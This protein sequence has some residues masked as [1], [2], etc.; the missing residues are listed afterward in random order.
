MKK[1]KEKKFFPILRDY[2][3]SL[4]RKWY[5]EYKFLNNEGKLC[6]SK[7]SGDINHYNTV[8]QREEEAQK[9]IDYINK[10]ADTPPKRPG[11]RKALPVGLQDESLLIKL[12]EDFL[13]QRKS[14]VRSKS[15]STY[16]SVVYNFIHWLNENKYSSS[17]IKYFGEDLASKYIDSLSPLA[18]NT[19]NKHLVVLRM[20]FKYALKSKVIKSNPFESVDGFSKVAVPAAAFTPEQRYRLRREIEGEDP[21]LWLFCM[22]IFY[23]F[24]RPGELRMLKVENVWL[25]E[26]KIEIPA[27]VSKNKKR[28]FVQIPTQLAVMLEDMDI[29]QYPGNYYLFTADGYPGLKHVSINYMSN[30]FR[31]YLVK[32]KFSK[33]HVL[34]S[35]KH[36]GAAACA[37]AGIPV[38]DIQLQLRHH[39]LDQTDQYLKSMGL[40]ETERIKNLFPDV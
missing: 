7:Y 18:N 35:W 27:E 14:R 1:P 31:N 29:R 34:Y 20:L 12:V 28:Q 10:F 40:F 25:D 6:K 11:S 30:R 32:L 36:T 3:K 26:H 19:K 38:K 13:H 16:K 8:E 2:K 21:Q 22:M 17:K 37:K 5:I 15:Y 24:I 33:R 4:T 9:A 23:T 39:S